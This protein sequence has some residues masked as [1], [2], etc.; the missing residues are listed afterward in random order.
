MNGAGRLAA[1]LKSAGVETVFAL[2]GNQIMPVFDAC[3]DAGIRIVHVRHEGAAVYMADGWAQLTGGIGVALL[4]A[5]P[6]FANG[7]SPLFSAAQAVSPVLLLSGD[8]PIAQDGKGAFQE[9]DQTAIT[10]PLVKHAVRV[11]RADE[12][13][14]DT[15]DAIRLALSGRQ[16]PVHLALPFDV[17]TGD[18]TGAT[19]LSPADFLPEGQPLSEETAK[20]ITDAIAG[21]ERPLALLGPQFN[22]SRAGEAVSRLERALGVPVVAMESPRG[23]RDPAL[24]ALA[25]ILAD[26]DLV[27]SL[28]KRLDFTLG[29][30][31]H[32]ALA[33]DARL[34]VVDPDPAVLEHATKV[35]GD[36]LV[37][38]EVADIAGAIAAI[39]GQA[40][41][42][43][44][45]E[46]RTDV[47]T[48]LSLRPP[49]QAL[50][51]A[52]HPRAL[53]DAVNRLLAASPAP[54]LVCD[55]GEFGQWAQAFCSAPRRIINGPSGAIGGGIGYALAAKLAQPGATVVALMG[56]GTAGFHFAE[57]ET[58][59]REGAP[60]IAV[61][62]NDDRWN[63]EHQ[64]QLRD[65]GPDRLTGCGLSPGL[66][67]DQ[68]AAALGAHGEHVTD[69]AELE[70]ALRRAAASG[71]P[72]CVNVAIE[73]VAA[74]TVARGSTGSH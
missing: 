19:E 60:F 17:L 16:G 8:S 73:G 56:D 55:G 48:A 61:I 1:T 33:P 15:R 67:Y 25:D 69:I 35:A 42:F 74:P 23:L 13:A 6:G 29:F 50:A 32:K 3:L 54:V 43:G 21:A 41:P 7:L 14:A 65:Y 20:R 37:L 53:C 58:A 71:K 12:M 57:F 49:G 28:G 11:A 51:D 18:E 63:A 44:H 2:S 40:S 59:A 24:G 26:S 36:R 30:A 38:G 5:G 72:A 47:S 62:G 66:R 31:G 34:V 39:A 68:A 70:P 45:K 4:T 46:W 10:R 9:M 52:I 27:V 22:R 64:I